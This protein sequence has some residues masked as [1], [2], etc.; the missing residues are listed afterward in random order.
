MTSVHFLPWISWHNEVLAFAVVLLLSGVLLRNFFAHSKRAILLPMMVWPIGLLFAVVVIQL[1]IGRILFMG[2]AVV[3]GFYLL[4]CL[5]AVTVGCAAMSSHERQQTSG[6]ELVNKLA[7]LLIIGGMTSAIMALVQALDVW[8]LNAWITR[9][10]NLRR[11]GGNLAQPNQLATLL[12]FSIA[13][14]AYLFESRRLSALSAFP[15]AAVLLFGLVI[16]ESRSGVLGLLF[17]AAW[18]FAKRRR[19]GFTLSLPAAGLWLTFFGCCFWFWPT[20]FTFIQEGRWTESVISQ[21]NVGDSGRLAIWQQLWQAVLIRPWFGWGLREVSSAQNAIIH[22]YA[23]SMPVTYAHNIVMDLAVGIG[24]PLTLLLTGVTLVWLWRRA[25]AVNDALTWYCLAAAVPLGVH[26]MLEYPFAYAYL[27]V[28]V[29]LLVGVLEARLAPVR[30]LRMPWWSATMAWML[31]SATM[32]WSVIEYTLI[33]ADF[34]IVRFEALRVGHTPFDYERPHIILLTQLDAL[35]HGGRIVPKP[36][37]NADEVELARKVA[38]RFPWPATQ[39]R[40]A[41]SLALNGNAEEAVRQLR[42]IRAVHGE[43]TYAQIKN[44]WTLLAAEKYPQLHELKLP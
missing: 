32:V 39:N 35:L 44:G 5:L 10:P 26:S 28:P 30:G 33:E 9:L 3:L 29:M 20:C 2:D 42:V 22:S 16:T 19:L 17:I 6:T 43:L 23:E 24:L 11:P 15:I 38:L 27:L 4:L 12:L 34:R 1:A 7:V 8:E 37:M 14:T 31:I 36:G 13:S 18:W 21:I 40:Y 25:R 41:Q